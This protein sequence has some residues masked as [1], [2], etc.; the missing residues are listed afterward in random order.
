MSVSESYRL[1]K[2]AFRTYQPPKQLRLLFIFHYMPLLLMVLIG[3][4]TALYGIWNLPLPLFVSLLIGL[5]ILL[6]G[7]YIYMKWELHWTKVYHGQ[8]VTSGIFTSIRH[9]HYTSLLI[10]GFGLGF[11]FW[12][13]AAMLL[14]ILAVPLMIVS[15]LDEEHRLLKEYGKD[16]EEFMQKTPYRI[17][18]YLY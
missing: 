14:A 11:F 5:L 6:I 2:E 18:P 3:P 8:L 9:P 12:S 1:I 16:Y 4:L 10:I 13:A 7:I 15:I 17:I